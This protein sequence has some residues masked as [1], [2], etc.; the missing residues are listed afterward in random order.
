MMLLSLPQ[1]HQVKVNAGTLTYS[2][3]GT[4]TLQVKYLPFLGPK[5]SAAGGAVLRH[6]SNWRKKCRNLEVAR[7][8]RR[9]VF[10]YC[11][12]GLSHRRTPT[13]ILIPVLRLARIEHH[14]SILVARPSH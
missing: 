5:R 12:T 6:M 7:T 11:C 2:L 14:S 3:Y 1:W 4:A 10:P 9:I 8:V 13:Q